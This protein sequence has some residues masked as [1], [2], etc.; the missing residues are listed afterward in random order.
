M[1][2]WWHDAGH[3]TKMAAMPIYGKNP[4]KSSSPE[5]THWFPRNLVYSIGEL[6]HHSLFKRWPSRDLDLSYGKV[7]FGYFG[8][9]KVKSVDFSETIAACDLKVGRCRQ[10][11]E[12]MKVCEYWRSRPFLYHI[13]SRLCMFYALLA[14]D[15]RW[16]FTGPLVLWY[17][18]LLSLQLV[19][20][21]V[22]ALKTARTSSIVLFI[23]Y[24]WYLE[25]SRNILRNQKILKV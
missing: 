3:M 19:L 17:F 10:L 23:F 18:Y 20:C 8:K 5:P 21:R 4:L 22:A 14:K 12:I 7:K 25:I 1:K 15:I 9:W 24:F 2:I 16:A 6:A 13:F 11:I